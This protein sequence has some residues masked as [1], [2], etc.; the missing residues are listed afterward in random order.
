MDRITIGNKLLELGFSAADRGFEYTIEAVRVYEP[1]M[2][3]GTVYG[4]VAGKFNVEPSNAERCI[5]NAKEKT[6]AFKNLT[7]R[8]LI[9]RIRWN[10]EAKEAKG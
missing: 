3:M 2:T 5:R 10:L 1:G 8:E 7:N 9:A 4:M 6:A